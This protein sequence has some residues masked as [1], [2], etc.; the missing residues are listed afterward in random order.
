MKTPRIFSI[1]VVVLT[2]VVSLA[3]P[4]SGQVKPPEIKA[5]AR[6]Q[7]GYTEIIF[8]GAAGPFQLQRRDSLD[9]TAPWSDMPDGLVTELEPGVF[10]GQFPNGRDDFA[11]Y[12]VVSESDGISDLKGWTVLLKVSPPANGAYFTVGESPVVTVTILDTFAQ[13]LGRTDFSSLS[14]YMYGPQ[15]TRQTVTAVKLLNASTDRTQR[16]HHYIDLKTHPDVQ[17]NGDELTYHLKPVTDELPGTY[18]VSVWSVLASDNIQQIMKFADVQI[19]TTNVE[20]SLVADEQSGVSS[21]AACHKGSIS[22]R[23]YMH[24]IDPGFSPTG[25]WSLDYTPVKSCKSCHNNNGYA[26]YT[27]AS[28]PGGRA[29]DPIVRRVHGLHMGEGLKLPFNTDPV[30]GD[31]RAYTHLTF[32][33]D[34][35]SCVKCHVDDR[36]MT[37]LSQMACAACHD[38]VWFGLA[39]QLPAGMVAHSGGVVTDDNRCAL[40]HSAEGLVDGVDVSHDLAAPDFKLPSPP[41]DVVDVTLTP[42][43]NGRFYVAGEKPVV[44]LVIKDD[45]G[46]PIDHTKVTDGNFSTA[47][48]MVY[49]PRSLTVPV[50]TSAARNVNSTLRASVSNNKDGPWSGINGKVFTIAINGSTPQN[51]TI[52][53][54]GDPVTPAEVVASL[55]PVITNLN[56]G[57][58]AFVSGARVNIK[59]L[60]QGASARIEIY[61]GDVTTAMVWKRPPNTVTDPDVTVAAASIAANDLRAL[62]DPLDYSDPMVTR[63]NAN[64]TYRLDDVA[65]LAP[66]TYGVYAYQLPKAGKIAGLTNAVGLGHVMFQVGTETPEK[67]VALNCSDC[68]GDT[69]F[70]LTSGPIH[71]APFDPDYCK[72]CHDYAHTSIGDAFKNQGGTSLNGWSGF[73]AVPIVRRVHGVHFAHYLEHSEEIYANATKQ[74]FGEIIFPQ[75]VRN[76]TK[77]HAQTDAWKQEPS[78]LA[79]L[80]CH[81]SDAAKAHGRLMTYIPDVNDPYGPTAVESCIVCHGADAEFSPDKVHQIGSPYVP[82][83]PREP[84][85]P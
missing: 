73:G 2:L 47:S 70:H 78:R 41:I 54:A 39:T 58:K 26:A 25:N 71:P 35:R 6:P 29:S 77:C 23:L 12:R 9:P 3:Q 27:D 67:K 64:I 45:L 24:H 61:N 15:D 85:Q 37:Q 1:G 13:G 19:G 53:G 5:I 49:G 52:V 40:C 38:N 43:A 22:G 7:A 75:D 68:H 55:N 10:L 21:C 36:W 51:I 83:Y 17:I 80:A 62:S 60:I 20:K 50:L 63:T 34:A 32:P 44:T 14:L 48:L 28:A 4:A 74:T 65:G 42:P 46:N 69:I 82:P 59:T 66:G 16:T 79:C 11:F 72:A 56:G 84:T 30:T 18:T 31:F 8:H 81:D 57:A 76:C 33:A